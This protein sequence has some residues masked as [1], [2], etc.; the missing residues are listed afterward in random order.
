[1]TFQ[2]T[3]SILMQV[4][5]E[6]KNIVLHSSDMNIIKATFEGKE[7]HFLEYKPWQ[8]IAI[9]LPK[10]L[11]KGQYV[12]DINYKANLSS[13]YDGFYNSSYVDTNGLKRYLQPN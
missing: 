8:Q 5:H 3:V 6:T 4:L 10:D 1:M 11:K 2:G 13:S 7:V 9:K 12:L